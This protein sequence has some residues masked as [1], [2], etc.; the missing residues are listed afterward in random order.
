MPTLFNFIGFLLDP[1]YHAAHFLENLVRM[2]NAQVGLNDAAYGAKHLTDCLVHIVD[3]DAHFFDHLILQ[4]D[5][6]LL[7]NGQ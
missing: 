1:V 3:G 7:C 6:L 5:L 4:F 2:L